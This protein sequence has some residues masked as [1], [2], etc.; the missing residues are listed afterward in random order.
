MTE[1]GDLIEVKVNPHAKRG[2]V[3]IDGDTLRVSVVVAAEQ[4]RANRAVED[5]VAEAL[6]LRRRKVRIVSGSK[7]RRK[8]IAIDGMSIDEIRSLLT[9]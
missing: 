1:G 3:R 6:G 4:G 8:L 2:Q 5:A 9:D 7:S